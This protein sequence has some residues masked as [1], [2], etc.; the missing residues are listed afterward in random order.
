MDEYAFSYVNEHAQ[1]LEQL[2]TP[3]PKLSASP[4]PLIPSKRVRH[5]PLATL[6]RRAQSFA[7]RNCEKVVLP[8]DA[9]DY[10]VLDIEPWYV[11]QANESQ[12]DVVASD[13]LELRAANVARL[14]SCR[15]ILKSAETALSMLDSIKENFETV[16]DQTSSLQTSCNKLQEEELRLNILADEVREHL[17][18]FSYLVSANRLLNVPGSNLVLEKAYQDLLIDLQASLD[19]LE[20]HPDYH[21]AEIYTRQ[22]RQALTKALTLARVHFTSSM[23]DVSADILKRIQANAM[24]KNTQSALLYTKFRSR[25]HSIRPLVQQLEEACTRHDEYSSLLNDCRQAYFS[26]RKRLLNPVIIDAFQDMTSI[27]EFT[28]FCTSAISFVR[29]L[30]SDEK[31]LYDSFFA[32]GEEEFETYLGLL[33]QA[34]TDALRPRVAAELSLTNLCE[35]CS[36]MQAQCSRYA[37]DQESIVFDMSPILRTIMG[38]IQRRIVLKAQGVVINEIQ[39]Y[40]PT[41]KDLDYP[42]SLLK[43]NPPY[44]SANGNDLSVLRGKLEVPGGSNDRRSSR[45]SLSHDLE[46]LNSAVLYERWYVT[47]RVSISLL[48]KIYK[49]VQSSIFDDLAH[50]V[51]RSCIASLLY[52]S[53]LIRRRNQIDGQLFL[54]KFLLILKEQVAAFDIEYNR[55]EESSRLD[56]GAVA[57]AFWDLTG[58]SA[59]GLFAPTALYNLASSTISKLSA[60]GYLSRTVENM[61]DARE[62][63]NDQ[64]RL[65]IGSLTVHCADSVTVPLRSAMG[66]KIKATNELKEADRRFRASCPDSFELWRNSLEL[67]LEDEKVIS[68]LLGLVQDKVLETFERFS[69]YISELR[70]HQAPDES[71]EE[72]DLPSVVDTVR[73]LN[74]ITNL[75]SEDESI[76]A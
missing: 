33:G 36:T 37:E 15:K 9:T 73:W 7:A 12:A 64:T 23:K 24:N 46:S 42:G 39:G 65:V 25:G 56:L 76:D 49:L 32:T 35:I 4:P 29:V 70:K 11:D 18:P 43:H 69:H 61:S 50:E 66:N 17:R 44:K 13:L 47:L 16:R 27:T 5:P 63:L 75:Q 68:V 28:V 45:A 10:P 40:K 19:F 60:A 2:R 72:L 31:E 22:Y 62:E 34:F 53:N 59:S 71:T 41:E 3:S 58:Q 52:A 67:Y 54:L 57:G 55:T 74:K 8:R 38:E 14:A 21:D 26:T 48:S 51:V 20:R 30:A 6:R 1:R